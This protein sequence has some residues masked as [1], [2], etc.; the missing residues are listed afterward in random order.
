MFF[1][2]RLANIILDMQALH[3]TLLCNDVYKFCLLYKW[4]RCANLFACFQSVGGL[5]RRPFYYQIF[6]FCRFIPKI[7]KIWFRKWRWH[8]PICQICGITTH[9]THISVH[10][11]L[12]STPNVFVLY[13]GFLF[14]L[15]KHKKKWYT[16]CIIF[17]I[18]VIYFALV[19]CTIFQID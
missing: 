10:F 18:Y 4:E 8:S 14:K 12:K 17:Y 15:S 9:I 16:R 5:F 2:F 7:P 19:N 3:C 1:C 11:T 6:F 13:I